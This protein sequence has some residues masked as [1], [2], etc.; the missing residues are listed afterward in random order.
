MKQMFFAVLGATVAATSAQA[1]DVF[2]SWQSPYSFPTANDTS[3]V[4]QQARLIELQDED[5]FETNQD[6]N[7]TNNID[8]VNID[9]MNSQTSRSFSN[10]SVIRVVDGKGNE[11][12]VKQNS[13]NNDVNSENNVIENNKTKNNN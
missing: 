3:V 8:S 13:E 11:I 5:F 9:T 7:T 1:N 4:L 6:I 10:S 12:R 2:S